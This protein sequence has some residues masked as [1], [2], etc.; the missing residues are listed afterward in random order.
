[1][2]MDLNSYINTK[3]SIDKLPAIYFDLDG[4]LVSMDKIDSYCLQFIRLFKK[5]G[6]PIG[7]ATGRSYMEAA[8][9]I[10]SIEPNLPCVL[11]DGQQIYDYITDTHT[12]LLEFPLQEYKKLKT[13]IKDDMLFVDEYYNHYITDSKK[14]RRLFCLSM[15]VNEYEFEREANKSCQ[16]AG[17]AASQKGSSS[18]TVM[19]DIQSKIDDLPAELKQLDYYCYGTKWIKFTA[20]NLK[21][22]SKASAVLN[23]LKDCSLTKSQLWY[24]GDGANDIE[25]MNLATIKIIMQN[26]DTELKKVQNGFVLNSSIADAMKEIYLLLVERY[27]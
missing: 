8:H 22:I 24:F 23:I 13:T 9:H 10:R 7:I 16:I 4:T 18:I 11:C 21:G 26:A 14:A 17:F 12:S 25:L 1:M 3:C 2:N 20:K 19:K 6:I 27:L 15:K 5:L